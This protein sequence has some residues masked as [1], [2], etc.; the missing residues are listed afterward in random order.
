MA[1]KWYTKLEVAKERCPVVFYMVV[2]Q[3]LRSHGS[4]INYDPNWAFPDCNS[5][6]TWP[7]DLKWCTKLDIVEKKCPIVFR[8]HQSN[9]KVTLAEKSIRIQ[10]ETTRLVA[11]I[12]SLRFAL[13]E[14]IHQISRSHG[15]KNR[16]LNPIWVR[17]LGWSQLSN[18]SDLPCYPIF[19]ICGPNVQNNIAHKPVN[20]TFDFYP[21][22]LSGRRGIVVACVCVRP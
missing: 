15:L 21:S 18:P 6:L 9:S 1:T 5:S 12:K 2:H 13:F 3:I 19:L 8:D 11:A 17:L 10:F 22:G 14:I 4:K 16:W 20:W 7:M